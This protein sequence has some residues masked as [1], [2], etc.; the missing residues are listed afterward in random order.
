MSYDFYFP[1]SS[2]SSGSGEQLTET[3]FRMKEAEN[4]RNNPGMI[5]FDSFLDTVSGRQDGSLPDVNGPYFKDNLAQCVLDAISRY[6]KLN[7]TDID[8][9]P[10]KSFLLTLRNFSSSITVLRITFYADGAKVRTQFAK[11]E[12][13]IDFDFE[14]PDSVF[15]TTFRD[16]KMFVK[17]CKVNGL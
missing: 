6:K 9:S 8:F 5:S 15:V 7:N 2:A 13:I 10:A 12:F 17:D 1:A 4:E 3:F 16:D 11:T 14:E